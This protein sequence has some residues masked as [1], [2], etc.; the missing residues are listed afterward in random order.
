MTTTLVDPVGKVDI[1]E[2]ETSTEENHQFYE[3]DIQEENVTSQELIN[4]K[5]FNSKFRKKS[6]KCQFLDNKY[7]IDQNDDDPQVLLDINIKVI[8]NLLRNSFDYK[9]NLV[10]TNVG[11]NIPYTRENIITGGYQI[12]L[13]ESPIFSLLDVPSYVIIKWYGF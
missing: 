11:S 1:I 13:T 7:T 2:A 10:V 3:V 4:R 12:E 8:N 6:L 5:Y 9:E